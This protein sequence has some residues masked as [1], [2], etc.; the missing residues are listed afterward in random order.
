MMK[1]PSLKDLFKRKSAAEKL[2]EKHSAKVE[3]AAPKAPLI[4]FQQLEAVG[5]IHAAA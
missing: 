1:L 2:A 4:D 5:R 3:P